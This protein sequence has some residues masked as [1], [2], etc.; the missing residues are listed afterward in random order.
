MAGITIQCGDE[1]ARGFA[2]GNEAVVTVS[3]GTG[4]S[5]MVEGSTDEGRGCVTVRAIQ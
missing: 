5:L 1:M 3:A 2:R 4:D